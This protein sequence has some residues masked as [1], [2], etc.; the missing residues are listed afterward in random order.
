M[1]SLTLVVFDPSN[2][3]VAPTAPNTVQSTVID[4]CSDKQ[5]TRVQ[6][7]WLD[8]RINKWL[9]RNH[10]IPI[11]VLQPRNQ[12]VSVCSQRTCIYTWSSFAETQNRCGIASM[13]GASENIPYCGYVAWYPC[14]E[15]D[16]PFSRYLGNLW[17]FY[18]TSLKSFH[19]AFFVRQLH[20][21]RRKAADTVD[22]VPLP[23]QSAFVVELRAE[24]L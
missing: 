24:P 12:S 7:R 13:N 8:G 6:V 3:E 14:N 2:W 9:L 19:G 22:N 11:Y 16:V 5:T 10:V 21:C 20:G 23:W 17:K 15:F 1:H 18:T 4:R